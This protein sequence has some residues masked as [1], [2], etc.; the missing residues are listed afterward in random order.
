M[1]RTL[2]LASLVLTLACTSYV[3]AGTRPAP[4]DRIRVASDTP[5]LVALGGRDRVPRGSCLATRVSGR[6]VELR[7]DTLVL[8]GMP[9]V[10]PAAGSAC[11][12]TAT[13]I[14]VAPDAPRDVEVRA[15]DQR[16]T[17][18]AVSAAVLLVLSVDAL[19]RMAFPET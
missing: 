12:V 13:V 5:F 6:V 15:P 17:A 18:F 8:G 3:P 7:G 1:F 2:L 14:F 10:T 9:L 19:L 11:A 16:K 4:S